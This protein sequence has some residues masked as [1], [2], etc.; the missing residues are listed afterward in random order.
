LRLRVWRT[1]KNLGQLFGELRKTAGPEISE[2][3][4]YQMKLDL[5][6]FPSI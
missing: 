6:V 1:E 2:V 3:A 5:A 4:D